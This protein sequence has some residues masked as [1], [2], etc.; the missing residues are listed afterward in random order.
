M[1]KKS[2]RRRGR[3]GIG[4]EDVLGAA[5]SLRQQ[6]RVVGPTNVRLQLGRGSYATITRFLREL[7][8]AKRPPKN[9]DN[10]S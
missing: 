7:G 9:Q 3:P 8:F 1:R 5:E 6:G 2:S 4:L 10:D